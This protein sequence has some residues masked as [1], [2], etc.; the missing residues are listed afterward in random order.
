MIAHSG[1]RAARNVASRACHSAR[2]AC[3]WP[4]LSR[5]QATV[6]ALS[7]MIEDDEDHEQDWRAHGNEMAASLGAPDPEPIRSWSDDDE[8]TWAAGEYD[9]AD[10][11]EGL[12][13][14]FGH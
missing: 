3:D 14:H 6:A 5:M 4:K 10:Y 2:L 8:S 7:E 9:E 13:R 12:G 1:L 11:N